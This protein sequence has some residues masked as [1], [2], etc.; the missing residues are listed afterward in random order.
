MKRRFVKMHG[1]GNDFVLIDTRAD[2]WI[3]DVSVIRSLG[4]RRR[5]I[6]FDQLLVIEQ[7]P[8]HVAGYRIFNADGS[9]AGQCGNGVRCVARWLADRGELERSGTLVGPGGPVGI[10]I[11][12]DH[13]EVTVDMGEPVLNP[14]EIPF[15]GHAAPT[16]N[17]LVHEERTVEFVALSMGNPHAV[18]R[19]SDLGDGLIPRLA[20]GLQQDSRFPEGVNVGF[21]QVRA[22][23]QVGL[24]VIERGV[25]E[26]PAC[27]SG[28][29]AAVVAGRLLEIL[30][31]AVRVALPGG[32]LRI[33]WKGPGETVR[34]TG[35]AAYAFEGEFDA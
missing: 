26:T 2:G 31:P 30:G 34:M 25:G 22:P 19:C 35:P 29:C 21:L 15:V 13:H 17:E 32:E 1:L 23:D 4:D 20:A 14:D 33:S 3:P 24:R 7:A 5:G 9:P 6:G 27:G 16:P 12:A 10:E 28:A 18:I 11:A 8:G